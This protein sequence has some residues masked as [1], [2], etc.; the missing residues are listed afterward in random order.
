MKTKDEIIEF[1][2]AH[3]NKGAQDDEMYVYIPTDEITDNGFEM[4]QLCHFSD[5]NKLLVCL[6]DESGEE[7]YFVEYDSLSAESREKI[8]NLPMWE[9]N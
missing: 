9:Q 6:L 8:E 4:A 7:G 3:G 5:T 2:N 1:I